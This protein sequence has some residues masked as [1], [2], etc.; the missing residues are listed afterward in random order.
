MAGEQVREGEASM[1]KVGAWYGVSAAAMVVFAVAGCG[2]ASGAVPASEAAV[3][4]PVCAQSEGMYR[5]SPK[6]LEGLRG[7]PMPGTP[8]AVVI[9]RYGTASGNRQLASS[10]KVTDGSRLAQLQTAVNASRELA[11]GDFTSCMQS[12][13][14]SAVVL[15]EYAGQAD[16]FIQVDDACQRVAI[17]T[18]TY[19]PSVQLTQLI[20]SWTGKW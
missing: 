12:D 7:V 3:R 17:P 20:A 19:I 18:A 14:K 9:C 4:V 11:P 2:A 1:R 15:V 13:G 10:L 6:S 8:A 16:R 5:L